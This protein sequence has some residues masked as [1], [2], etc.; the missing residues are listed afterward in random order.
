VYIAATDRS[1]PWPRHELNEFITQN[2]IFICDS[3][4]VV[5]FAGDV[6]ELRVPGQWMDAG[7]LGFPDV[8]TP[9]AIAAK[10]AHPD[11][12][13]VCL[14]SDGAFSLTSWDFETRVALGIP[15]IGVIASKSVDQ[16]PHVTQRSE[17]ASKLSSVPYGEIARMLGGYGEEVHDPEQ[18]QPALQRARESGKCALI[19]VWIDPLG[20]SPSA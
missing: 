6:I 16:I 8:A 2:T 9:F 17:I 4:D 18:I 12:E 19:N 11:K 1:F 15:F 14:F 13:V 3:G 20:L 10:L 7:P 5:N